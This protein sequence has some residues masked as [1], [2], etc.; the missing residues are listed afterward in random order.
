MICV[1]CRRRGVCMRGCAQ[2][3][4]TGTCELEYFLFFF[5][6][7]PHTY[8]S[9][10]AT[11]AHRG[12]RRRPFNPVVVARA[13]LPDVADEAWATATA[14][15]RLAAADAPVLAWSRLL[16]AAGNSA[17]A[18]LALF[19]SAQN[20]PRRLGGR[21]RADLHAALF[22]NVGEAPSSPKMSPRPARPRESA[23]TARPARAASAHVLARCVSRLAVQTGCSTYRVPP[24]RCCARAWRAWRRWVASGRRSR[25]RH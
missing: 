19:Y 17:L 24:R 3:E 11:S 23:A 15:K 25:T 12:P 16:A 4:C 10:R 6:L 8:V 20:A 7:L 22:V 1:H 2:R 18:A 14:A 9:T 13:P 5:F 21:C